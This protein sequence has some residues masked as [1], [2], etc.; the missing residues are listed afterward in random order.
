MLNVEYFSKSDGVFGHMD[1]VKEDIRFLIARQQRGEFFQ[2]AFF[3]FVA[4]AGHAVEAEIAAFG[5]DGAVFQRVY[6]V[7]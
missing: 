7:P 4:P 5:R 6:D 2:L 1:V 3:V